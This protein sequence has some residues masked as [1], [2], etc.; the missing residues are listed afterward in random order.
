ME[1]T[2]AELD[3]GAKKGSPMKARRAAKRSPRSP[4]RS[5][6]RSPKRS[7]QRSPKRTSAHSSDHYTVYIDFALTPQDHALGAKH[8][9][10]LVDGMQ[11]KDGD[12]VQW[13]AF[14][15]DHARAEVHTHH[16]K[17]VMHL[18]YSY[19]G[20]IDVQATRIRV[21]DYWVGNIRLEDKEKQD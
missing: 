19:F 14:S 3:G 5:P 18:Y 21:K 6:R 4:K 15:R 16:A 11:L 2:K 7:P 12:S 17:T 8:R 10:M 13:T 20:D 1:L 9:K